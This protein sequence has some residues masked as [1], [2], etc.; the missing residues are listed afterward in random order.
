MSARDP[1]R[2]APGVFNAS[3]P[4]AEE[5]PGLAELLADL[6]PVPD[7]DL[8]PA[9][10]TVPDL[11]PDADLPRPPLEVPPVPAG[12]D[13]AGVVEH[14]RVWTERMV[15]EMREHALPV[16]T[17]GFDR[18]VR[19]MQGRTRDPEL[20]GALWDYREGKAGRSALM[21]HPAFRAERDRWYAEVRARHEG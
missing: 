4:P 6:D 7:A 14:A 17:D 8:A 1:H 19:E 21:R 20:T 15:A 2:P 3:D 18:M 12:S 9:T 16:D 13:L 11:G 10:L 5:A